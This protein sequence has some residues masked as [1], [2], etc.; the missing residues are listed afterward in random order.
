MEWV[1]TICLK[2]LFEEKRIWNMFWK[3]IVPFVVFLAHSVSQQ[4]C[5]SSLF[6]S[7]W[8]KIN[9][10]TI[11]TFSLYIFLSSHDELDDW[12]PNGWYAVYWYA[13]Q[14]VQDGLTSSKKRSFIFGANNFVH[15]FYSGKMCVHFDI[16]KSSEYN[17]LKISSEASW[18]PCIYWV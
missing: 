5:S 6:R 13:I 9:L 12:S 15:H 3:T 7:L 11:H 17:F 2:R 4:N 8:N 18:T 1:C 14:G 16:W 10:L